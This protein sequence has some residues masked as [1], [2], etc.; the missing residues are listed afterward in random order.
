VAEIT[1]WHGRMTP[2][3]Y[4]ALT[5]LVWEHVNPYGRLDLD[6]NGMAKAMLSARANG[7]D[8]LAAVEQM[9]GWQQLE[10]MVETMGQNLGSHPDGHPG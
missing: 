3:D 9:I 1:G 8:P 4:A 5:P 10:E 7:T 2:R 6:M